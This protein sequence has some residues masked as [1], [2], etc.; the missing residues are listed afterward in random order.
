MLR[1]M[2]LPRKK[3]QPPKRRKAGKV[4]TFDMDIPQLDAAGGKLV[5]AGF[6]GFRLA[7]A[8][9]CGFVAFAALALALRVREALVLWAYIRRR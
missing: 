7:V 6:L 4:F 9:G 8:A 3:L 2:K 1:P 5:A